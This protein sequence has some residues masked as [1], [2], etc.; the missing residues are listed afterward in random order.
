M[1]FSIKR[2]YI[3]VIIFIILFSAFII[4]ITMNKRNNLIDTMADNSYYYWKRHYLVKVDSHK[5]KVV[6]PEQNYVTLSEGMGYGLLFTASSGDSNTFK[7][8]WNYTKQYLDENGLMNWKIGSNGKIMGF[9]SAT[10][11]DEDIAYALLLASRKWPNSG[12]FEEASKMINSIKNHEI[13]SDY[14][15]L[16]GDGWGKN[17]PLNPSYIALKY[18]TEFGEISEKKYWKKVV[19]VNINILKENFNKSTGLFPD[20]INKKNGNTFG[21]DAIRVPIRLVQFYRNSNNIEVINILKS[22]YKF[23]SNQGINNLVSGYSLDGIPLVNYINSEYL[24][25]FTAI[26]SVYSNSN[27]TMSLMNKLKETKNDSYYGSSLKTWILF[28]LSNRL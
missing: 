18:Y 28:I 7:M 8:L 17:P 10:D 13:S 6:V 9:G 1:Q 27:F 12:Y 2:F 23:I 4:M 5:M 3:I 25:S 22:Q 21:Y 24:S 26:G 11:A 20:W 14:T 15:I 16:P 19:E